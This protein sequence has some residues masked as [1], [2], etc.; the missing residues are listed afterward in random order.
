[1]IMWSYLVK[2]VMSL[3][4]EDKDLISSGETLNQKLKISISKNL[5][6]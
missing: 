4:Y 6:V 2:K 3:D 5:S 1:M